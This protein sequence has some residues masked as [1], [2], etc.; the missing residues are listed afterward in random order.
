[1]LN[2]EPEHPIYRPLWVRLLIV[3]ILAVWSVLE[4]V[5]GSPFWGTIAGG[6]GLFA[7]YELFWRFPEHRAKADAKAAAKAEADAARAR[8]GDEQDG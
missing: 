5:K 1:M 2:I 8:E 7:A 6:V 3:G 4:L